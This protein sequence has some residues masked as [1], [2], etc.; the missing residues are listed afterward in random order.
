MKLTVD[1]KGGDPCICAEDCRG[2][3]TLHVGTPQRAAAALKALII[4]VVREDRPL[5]S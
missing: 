3:V 1:V 4:A 2:A 5:T